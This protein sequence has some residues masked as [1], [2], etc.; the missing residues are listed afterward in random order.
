MNSSLDIDRI[1]SEIRFRI[2]ATFK[3]AEICI[4]FPQRDVHLDTLSPLEVNVVS[5]GPPPS[6]EG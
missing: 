2:D 6:S 1:N 3:E 5:K 4:A